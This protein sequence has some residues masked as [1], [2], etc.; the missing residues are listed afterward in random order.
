MGFL[1]FEKYALLTG[2]YLNSNAAVFEIN[3]P[4]TPARRL[5]RC[6]I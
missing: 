1:S 5:A 6:P 3:A 4:S 2:F